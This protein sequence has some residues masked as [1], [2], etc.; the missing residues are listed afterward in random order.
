MS[1]ADLDF[2]LLCSGRRVRYPISSP[3]TRDLAA[4]ILA[5][6]DSVAFL[7]RERE[8]LAVVGD[9]AGADGDDL[10]PLRLLLAMSGLRRRPCCSSG[11]SRRLTSTR[12][13]SGRSGVFTA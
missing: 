12:S 13:P 11:S 4:G 5:E 2:M 6:E 9:R 8:G 7:H 1:L 3:S 10:A